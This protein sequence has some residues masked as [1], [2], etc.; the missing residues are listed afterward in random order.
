VEAQRKADATSIPQLSKRAQ[1][2]VAGLVV[3]TD[4]KARAEPYRANTRLSSPQSA[5]PSTL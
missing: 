3:A 4:D 1:A 5:G 2:A